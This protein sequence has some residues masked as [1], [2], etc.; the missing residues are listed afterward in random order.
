MSPEAW[1]LWARAV[2]IFKDYARP[3][4]M[5]VAWNSIASPINPSGTIHVSNQDTWRSNAAARVGP[6][7]TK[8]RKGRTLTRHIFDP[9]VTGNKSKLSLMK[10]G[11]GNRRTPPTYA[12]PGMSSQLEFGRS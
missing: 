3:H 7:G 10:D 11:L 2:A 4:A 12:A 1:R 5:V 6:C 9:A 8:I